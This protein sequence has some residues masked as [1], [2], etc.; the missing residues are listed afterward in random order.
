MP[1]FI[2]KSYGKVSE[3]MVI[4]TIDSGFL[5]FASERERDFLHLKQFSH[6]HLLVLIMNNSL[7][8]HSFK[9]KNL[10]A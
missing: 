1:I 6:K 7:L 10:I 4:F 5:W 3:V 9:K 2:A 8:H